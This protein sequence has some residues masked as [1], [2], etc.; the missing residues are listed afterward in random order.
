METGIAAHMESGTDIRRTAMVDPRQPRIGQGITGVVLAL[1][2]VLG[3]PQV[4]PVVAAVLAGASLLGGSFNL[5]VHVYRWVRR[6]FRWGPPRELEEAA[7]PRFA[8]A[9]GF[10][11]TGAASLLYFVF[12]QHVAAWS[13]GVLVS[14]LALLAAATGLCVG[15][16]FY[17]F[18]K[19]VLTRRTG[20]RA[21]A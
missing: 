10:V 7:P 5:Y 8:N 4:L 16:E 6:T 18:A 2:F 9:L 17:V 14:A 21:G 15:C 11:F 13:L 1:G 19:R 12:R 3:W 20:V